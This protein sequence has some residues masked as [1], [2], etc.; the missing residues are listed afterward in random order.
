MPEVIQTFVYTYDELSPA[1]QETAKD[2]Y[3]SLGGRDG[4]WQSVYDDFALICDCLG[5][6]PKTRSVKLHGGG[7]MSE[8]CIWFS[9]FW[10][11]GDGA[12]FEGRWR[13]TRGGNLA[14]RAHA[15]Q[16]RVLHEIADRLHE[17]Q[18]R[19]FYQLVADIG[20]K[21][22]YCHE[23]AMV[24]TV[25]RDNTHAQPPTDDAEDAVTFAMRD[26]AR[27]LYQQLQ[28]EYDHITSESEIAAAIIANEY[29]FTVTGCRFG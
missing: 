21:G 22:R 29:T 14:I 9:G 11:Q 10:N 25:D 26:L 27:W 12:C 4:W 8:P 6:V 2:W 16:D 17:V 3:R 20:H 7:T 13:Y 15:P 1:A 24:I 23:Y 28:A 5:I 18:Q 19:N